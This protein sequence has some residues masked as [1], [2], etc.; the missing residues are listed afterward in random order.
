MW[1]SSKEWQKKKKKDI[2]KTERRDESQ[3]ICHC[4]TSK[5][6]FTVID[7]NGPNK[8]VL[9]QIH[10]PIDNNVQQYHLSPQKEYN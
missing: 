7:I 10:Y 8:E 5:L 1:Y 9:E 2:K 6:Y 4:I 3:C